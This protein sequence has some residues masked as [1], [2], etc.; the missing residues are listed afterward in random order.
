MATIFFSYSHADEP[1]RDQLEKHLAALKRQGLIESWHDR[2]IDVGRQF[3]SEISGHLETADVILLLVSSDFLAS[4]YCYAREMMRAMERHHAKEALV[5]PVILRPCDW[6]DT[7]FG[8]LQA[9]PKD[10]KAITLWPNADQ[11]F[12]DVVTSI[13]QV[14]R[15]SGINASAPPT[16]RG[17]PPSATIPL[18][19]PRTSNLRVKKRFTQRDEDQFLREGYDYLARFFENSLGELETRNP[20]IE[21]TFRRIDANR[22]TAAAYRDGE[23]VCQCSAFIGG[24]FGRGI[25]YASNDLAQTNSFNE[26]LMVEA[27]D[28]SL[29][30]KT[31]G[32]HSYG[33]E[34]DQKLGFEGAAEYL[35]QIFI[36]PLQRD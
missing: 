13:K 7:P 22:F 30:F 36:D 35:W 11:A 19:A 8:R 27:D 18:S 25:G 34:S 14:L 17:L 4:D 9:A 28:Q 24:M 3:D 10:A 31:M 32:F 26:N 1:L 29:Y 33:R 23:K 5:V 2:R 6:H 16:A 20:G 12:L 15:S 21:Q